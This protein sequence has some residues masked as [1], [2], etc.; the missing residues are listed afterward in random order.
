MHRVLIIWYFYQIIDT[1]LLLFVWYT[2][3]SIA[4]VNFTIQY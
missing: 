2:V 1:A 4:V 3:G